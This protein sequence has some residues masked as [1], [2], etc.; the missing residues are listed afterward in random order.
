MAHK[1]HC[2]GICADCEKGCSLDEM[3]PCS[4]DCENLMTDNTILVK[5]CL[6]SGCDVIKGIFDMVGFSDAEVIERYGEVA[7]YPY[8]V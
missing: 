2:G 8:D 6:S 5:E 3:I 7:A 4:P 1:Y